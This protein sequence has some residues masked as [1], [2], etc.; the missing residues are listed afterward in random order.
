MEITIRRAA[1]KD[2]EALCEIRVA[3]IRELGQTHYSEEELDAWAAGKGPARYEKRIAEQHV[4]VAERAGVPVGFG[5]FDPQTGEIIQLY[6]HPDHARQGVGT[7]ILEHL[8]QEARV[9]GFGVV[10]CAA[11]LSARDFYVKAGFEAGPR[12]R[13]RFRSGGEVDCVAMRK[14]LA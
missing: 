8:L 13:R 12:R 4:V 14:R 3:S 10:H 9:A 5:T 2:C 6:V 1:R 11:S 7:R